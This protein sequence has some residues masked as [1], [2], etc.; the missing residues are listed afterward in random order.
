VHATREPI[1]TSDMLIPHNTL[2]DALGRADALIGSVTPG[3]TARA[4]VV[5]SFY[6][7]VLR[8]LDAH[9]DGEDALLYSRARQRAPEHVVLFDRMEAEHRAVAASDTTAKELLAAWTADSG[10]GNAGALAGALSDLRTVLANHL[11]DEERAFLP[12]A[13]TTFTEEEWGELPGHVA[14]TFSGDKLWLIL[15]LVIEQMT[16][17]QRALTLAHLPPPVVEMW[18]GPGSANFAAFIAD[19][20]G[21]AETAPD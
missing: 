18:N 1:D 7:N 20:R 4:A 13:A 11:E 8:F 5:G 6:D 19:V 17:E 15:G 9:H 12:I 3:D 21:T 10:S 14:R 2:R 16:D